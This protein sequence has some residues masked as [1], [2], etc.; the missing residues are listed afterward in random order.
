LK[1]NGLLQSWGAVFK[2]VVFKG[3]IGRIMISPLISGVAMGKLSQ[4]NQKAF[5]EANG[6][7]YSGIDWALDL[8]EAEFEEADLRGVPGNLILRDCN[9]QFLITRE[10]AIEGKWKDIDLSGT[11]WRT[12]IEFFLEGRMQSELFVAPKRHPRF[13][14]LL[15]GLW[16]LRDA[17]IVI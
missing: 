1:T 8:R 15:D 17:G 5:N 12:A 2:H 3:K 6:D 4:D 10:K 9:S 16:K 14:A 13:R 11:H 7:F